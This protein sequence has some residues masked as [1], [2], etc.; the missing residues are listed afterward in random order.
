MWLCGMWGDVRGRWS[1]VMKEGFVS[2]INVSGI[3]KS[4]CLKSELCLGAF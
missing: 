4:R 3:D 1:A 2:V